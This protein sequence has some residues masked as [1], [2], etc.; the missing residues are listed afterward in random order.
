[1]DMIGR[2]DSFHISHVPRSENEEANVLA[3]RAS[4]YEVSRGLFRV[5]EKSALLG[6]Q[7]REPAG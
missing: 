7:K 4:R 1:M 3:Q 2:L 5:K 6:V